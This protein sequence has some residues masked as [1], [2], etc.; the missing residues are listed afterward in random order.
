M[1][2]QSMQ[3]SNLLDDICDTPNPG[4]PLTTRQ[5][6][7]DSWMLGNP[8]PHHLVPF[9]QDSGFNEN[10]AESPVYREF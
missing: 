1:I 7:E 2:V 6:T 8:T 10:R 3:A 4:G 5:P 9:S